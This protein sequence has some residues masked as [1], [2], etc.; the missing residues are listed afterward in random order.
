MTGMSNY[1]LRKQSLHVA[2]T[3]S[4]LQRPSLDWWAGIVIRII[5]CCRLQRLDFLG[6]PVVQEY[7]F[8][9]TLCISV[10]KTLRMA[11]DYFIFDHLLVPIHLLTILYP[12]QTDNHHHYSLIHGSNMIDFENTD[13]SFQTVYVFG[14]IS[15]TGR[16]LLTSDP[17]FSHSFH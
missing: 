16:L 9:K 13:T 2:T 4:K 12:V 14:A 15:P 7:A 10:Q 6:G 17:S 8:P 11:T 5:V 3:L 1:I